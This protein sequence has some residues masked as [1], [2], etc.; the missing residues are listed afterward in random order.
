[1]AAEPAQVRDT[2]VRAAELD[3]AL[4]AYSPP[5]GATGLMDRIV[6]G[7]P[8]GPVRPRFGWLVPAGMGA[9]LAAACAA[10]MVLGAR[11]SPPPVQDPDAIITAVGDEDVGAYFDEEA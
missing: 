1:M 4:A 6:A 7:A 3:W 9:G 5:R 2:L 11:L 8:K 10:G